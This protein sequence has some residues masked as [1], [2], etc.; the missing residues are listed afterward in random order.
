VGSSVRVFLIY[1]DVGAKGEHDERKEGVYLRYGGATTPITIVIS[2][3]SSSSSIIMMRLIILIIIVIL[4][5]SGR[6]ADALYQ[7]GNEHYGEEAQRIANRHWRVYCD[8]YY[9]S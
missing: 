8:Y 7:T 3:S 2:G 6:M 4:M 5:M 9:S 1:R